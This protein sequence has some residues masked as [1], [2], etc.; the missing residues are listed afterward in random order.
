MK[1]ETNVPGNDNGDFLRVPASKASAESDGHT[2]SLQGTVPVPS[3]VLSPY[4]L[5]VTEAHNYYTDPRNPVGSFNERIR[6]RNSIVR[7]LFKK[8]ENL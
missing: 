6:L 5:G 2:L 1:N 4:I 7:N 3:L 8:L